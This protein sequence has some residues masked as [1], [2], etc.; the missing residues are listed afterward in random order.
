MGDTLKHAAAEVTIDLDDQEL[1]PGN[2]VNASSVSKNIEELREKIKSARLEKMMARQLET[3]L[4]IDKIEIEEPQDTPELD[5]DN[6]LNK[7]GQQLSGVYSEQPESHSRQRTSYSTPVNQAY[8]INRHEPRRTCDE[9]VDKIKNSSE[10][11]SDIAE[12]ASELVQYLQVVEGDLAN[13]ETAKIRIKE[14]EE[15]TE[16]IRIE[17]HEAQ[18]I[19]DK[20]KKQIEM[21]ETMRKTAVSGHESA[22]SEILELKESI[23]GK[24]LELNNLKSDV[25]QSERE[26]NILKSEIGKLEAELSEGTKELKTTRDNLKNKDIELAKVVSDLNSL[27]TE[28][29]QNS[30]KLAKLQGKYNDLNKRGLE[31]QNEHFGKI[32]EL[33]STVRELRSRIETHEREKSELNVELNASNN[34]LVLHEEMI[35]ALSPGKA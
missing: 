35:A 28:N 6:V 29:E 3:E 8:A 16:Q 27:T 24:D 14:L 13:F 2:D 31:Q 30:D 23:R 15:K 17:R 20:Q 1:V 4:S 5:I 25:S 34:L 19:V 7:V 21:L 10:V 11:L 32:H 33:E 12:Q 9:M 18:A 26:K 22:K